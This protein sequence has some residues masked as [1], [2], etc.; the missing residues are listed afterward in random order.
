[1]IS[2]CVERT[3]WTKA[4]TNDNHLCEVFARIQACSFVL[5]Q[6]F[7]NCTDEEYR[8]EY[9]DECTEGNPRIYGPPQANPYDMGNILYNGPMLLARLDD[10]AYTE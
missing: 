3:Q 6:H 7:L 5:A 10:T 8:R 9:Y 4:W 2:F 1:M